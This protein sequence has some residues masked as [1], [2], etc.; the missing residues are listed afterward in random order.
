[1]PGQDQRG[2]GGLV[3]VEVG[4]EVPQLRVRVAHVR[5]RIGTAVGPGI[6]ALTAQEVILD[7]LDYRVEAERL[8]VD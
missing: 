4:G 1:M 7:E 6:K 5:P 2:Q 8:V 3:E